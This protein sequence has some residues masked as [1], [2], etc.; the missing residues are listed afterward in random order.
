[1]TH[2]DPG[3]DID[4]GPHGYRMLMQIYRNEKATKESLEEAQV[5]HAYG[6]L[7][8]AVQAHLVGFSSLPEGRGEWQVIPM[9]ETYALRYPIGSTVVFHWR[10]DKPIGFGQLVA[11]SLLA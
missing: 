1:M 7:A 2:A 5:T 8:L 3:A 10:K 4:V 9:S 11:I 6:A